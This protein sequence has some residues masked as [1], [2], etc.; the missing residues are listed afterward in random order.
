M[1]S[2]GID[3]GSTTIKCV[4]ID[5]NGKIL[6]KSYERH[7][8]KQGEKLLNLLFEIEKRFGKKFSLFMTGSGATIFSN[9]LDVKFIQ[10]VNAVSIAV[11]HYE[12]DTRTVIE[13]GGQD[14][15]MIFWQEVKGKKRKITTMNDKC[16]GG[17]G[18][19]I[20][21]IVSK[22]K[23]PVKKAVDVK[24]DPS[25]VYPVAAKCGVFAETDI[26]GLQKC[27]VEPDSLLI[28][29]FDAIV[30]QNLTVLTRGYTVAPKVLLLG[31][32]N[33]FFK[34]LQ[35]AWRYHIENLWKEK[36][37][38]Y[39]EKSVVIPEN[40]QIFAAL[41]AAI[42]GLKE[43][44]IYNGTESLLSFLSKGEDELKRKTGVV[45]LLKNKEEL[46]EFK[47]EVF[48]FSSRSV[49]YTSF[50]SEKI[51]VFIGIDGGSTSTKVVLI[52]KEKRVVEKAYTL[53][54]GNPITD[55]KRLFKEIRERLKKKGIEVSVRGVGVTGYAKEMIKE[56]VSADVAVVETV[57]HTISALSFFNDID[58]IVD[59]GGQDIKV[60]FMSNN[61][62]KDFKL[63]TQCSAGNGYFLQ[64]T[65][66]RF[67]F[68]VEEYA[69]VAFRAKYVPDFNFG[70]AVFLEQDIVDFQ[71]LGWEPHEI[72]AGLAK[73][74]P[75]NIWLYVVQEPN[76]RKFGKRFLL[77]GGTQRNLAAVKAQYDFIKERVPDAEIFVHPLTGE[78]GAFGAAVEAMKTEKTVFPGFDVVENMEIDVKS[79]E[80]T[81]CTF[82]S[83]RCVRTFIY[84]KN[85]LYIIAPCEKGS[86]ETIDE[87]KEKINELKEIKNKYPNMQEISAQ[88][89]F[90]E[91]TVDLISNKLSGI[92]VGMP[93]VLNFYSI[94]PF[95]YGYFKSL[96]AKVIFSP[97]TTEE[98]IKKDLVG[99]AIDPCFPSKIALAHVVNLIRKKP[100]I[101]FF[102][103]ILTLQK[104][105]PDSEDSKA[106]P[107][108]S[109]TPMVVKAALTKERNVF[110][111]K[112]IKFVSPII[113][114]HDLD[115]LEFEMFETFR[116]F[117]ISKEENS[118]AVRGGLL[119]LNKYYNTLKSMG[120]E[121]LD[122]A[123][124]EGKI[125]I[126][127]LGRPYHNDPGIN[128]GITGELQKKGYPIISVDSLPENRN[129]SL[130]SVYK[131]SYSENT[132]RKLWAAL[133]AASC[134]NMAVLDF[135][136]FRCG[137][138]A[139]TYRLIEKIMEESGTPYFT[140]HEIDEN[141]PSGAIKIRVETI[142]YFL[143]QYEKNL[144]N[145]SRR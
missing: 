23:I 11:E 86:V 109:G 60:I 56:I 136:S 14:A 55:V 97:Y 135:S 72:M 128:H 37:I 127:A 123:E 41:G 44:C 42:Y 91:P 15:K 3:I 111:E 82:C 90:K 30:L 9:I 80:S 12:A 141:K 120:K 107:T 1:Y 118:K 73:V 5:E 35:E 106:C 85:K 38:P 132:N 6:F 130:S 138:D 2:V 133:Y 26:T 94:A 92:T 16:A 50:S 144:L 70:C 19:T 131:K 101:I 126:L 115:Y 63:N 78:A 77:Q 134:P 40:S 122:R 52:D 8:A 113:H 98:M 117:G 125:V 99:G 83:N 20:D 88:L 48:R 110:A 22:L 100:D 13:L 143:R 140:F 74:L 39:S 46:E 67:G 145:S 137:P 129:I 84:F 93:R 36:S 54:S 29:L 69:D 95:F 51:D 24:Y 76:L 79:D 87:L 49:E 139:P 7:E 21:R 43:P 108:V 104:M 28:S 47:K 45:G 4:V 17:T 59:V 31:G 105:I 57:A 34:G 121:I 71:R 142:D 25:K 33:T 32:P 102:P 114:F 96:G 64:T 112:G 62:V 124:Q 116:E 103:K 58:V 18:A 65:A 66:E 68:S 119:A 53:S 81:R 10:E 75:K 89:C 27:G 61:T